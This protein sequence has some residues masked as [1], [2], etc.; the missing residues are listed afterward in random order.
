LN[1]KEPQN[2]DSLLGAVGL[3]LEQIESLLKVIEIA[4]EN[5]DGEIHSVYS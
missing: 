2:G 5:G 4:H 1:F 3:E